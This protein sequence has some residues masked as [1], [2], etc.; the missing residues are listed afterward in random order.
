M[1]GEAGLEIYVEDDGVEDGSRG[2]VGWK[3]GVGL[4]SVENFAE[5]YWNA[6]QKFQWLWGKVWQLSSLAFRRENQG[7]IVN[8]I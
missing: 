4:P 8:H 5:K 2:R 3:C 6:V 1:F 7:T